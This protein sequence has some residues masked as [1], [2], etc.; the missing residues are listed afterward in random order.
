[1]YKNSNQHRCSRPFKKLH[2]V[3]RLL[4]LT[5]EVDLNASV[6]TFIDALA[7]ATR[8]T[9]ALQ[10]RDMPTMQSAVALLRRLQACCHLAQGLSAA[11]LGAAAQFTTQLAQSFFMPLSLTCLAV[12]ARVRVSA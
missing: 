2:E 3:L 10:E 1:M 8:P 5:L 11:I 9:V 7:T 12:L 4:R 6:Q